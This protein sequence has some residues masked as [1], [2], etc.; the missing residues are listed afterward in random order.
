[1]IRSLIIILLMTLILSCKNREVKNHIQNKPGKDEMTELN[2]YFVQKDRERIQSFIERKNLKMTES[3]TG[4]WYSVEEEGNGSYF[5]DFDRIKMEYECSLLDGT[6]CYSSRE[7]GP[8]EIILGKSQLEAGLYEGFRLLKP[9]GK[10]IFIIPPF[11]GY[12]L[13]GD[14]KKIPSRAIIVY[15]I[16]II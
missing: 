2:R 9:G 12:G 11:L 16:S 13:V 10:A 15:D 6:L 14:G 7:S 4:L 3:P 1:M 8:K 5:K